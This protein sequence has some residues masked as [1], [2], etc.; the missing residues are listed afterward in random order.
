MKPLEAIIKSENDSLIY[1]AFELNNKLKLIFIEDSK[2]TKSVCAIQVGVG[3][4]NDPIEYQGLAHFLE[5]MLFI[6][7]EKYPEPSHY[8][9]FVTQ[10]G[11]E[12]NA[13]TNF[14]ST[15]FHHS[16]DSQFLVESLDI[17]CQHLIKPLFDTKYV[18]KEMNAVNSEFT[19]NDSDSQRSFQL[20]QFISNKQ[21]LFNRNIC[22]NLKTLLK[23]G[24]YEAL[25][26]F[27][28]KYYSANIISVVIYHNK[29]YQEYA[30][31]I[32]EILEQ[33]PNKELQLPS[34][35][36][37]VD[38]FD[39]E[40]TG[41]LV[42]MKSMKKEKILQ[43]TWIFEEQRSKYKSRPLNAICNVLGHEGSGTLQEL[44]SKLNL[45]YDLSSGI[46]QVEDYFCQLDIEMTLTELGFQQIGRIL[47]Y[48]GAYLA[49][50]REEGVP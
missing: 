44:L 48:L 16:I 39:A 29:P 9:N 35:K 27:H 2:V 31:E 5:H 11:G 10:K 19:S 7:S 24:I 41:K 33:I 26:Q 28:E 37:T 38:P 43:L 46:Y 17:L 14:V 25:K 21:S 49:M 22:G 3:A 20:L 12:L 8:S 32:V 36:S 30:H 34:F 47:S 42:H 45:I 4:M 6:G 40:H 15:N 13:W 23:D 1:N 18:D 50:M